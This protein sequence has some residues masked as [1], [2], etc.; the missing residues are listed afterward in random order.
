LD[1]DF[2]IRRIQFRGCGI[3]ALLVLLWGSQSVNQMADHTWTDNAMRCAA[4][5]VR[6]LRPFE[7][8][9]WAHFRMQRERLTL[10]ALYDLNWYG[11]TA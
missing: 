9:S 11:V 1:F 10:N 2:G 8:Y 7:R 5:R 6:D 4:A 3:G